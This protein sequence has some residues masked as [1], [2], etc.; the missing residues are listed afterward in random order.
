M[1]DSSDASDSLARARTA[2]AVANDVEEQL[3][4]IV[5]GLEQCVVRIVTQK[6]RRELAHGRRADNFAVLTSRLIEP[7]LIEEFSADY[8]S[9]IWQNRLQRTAAWLEALATPSAADWST[10]ADP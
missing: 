10:G 7:E 6:Q 9:R 8:Q 2:K 4:G 3:L 1:I 5:V